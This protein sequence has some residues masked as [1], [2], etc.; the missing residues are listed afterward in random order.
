[1]PLLQDRT[2]SFIVRLWC[3][4]DASG[5]MHAWRGGVEHVQS[6]RQRYF[7]RDQDLIA[8]I[9][10]PMADAGAAGGDADGD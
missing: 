4:Y 1:M 7:R 6:G 10:A 3:E 8:F 9:H 5:A 2:A